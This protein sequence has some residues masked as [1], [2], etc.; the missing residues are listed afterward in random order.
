MREVTRGRSQGAS[1]AGSEDFLLPPFLICT[2]AQW[3]RLMELLGCRYDITEQRYVWPPERR[4]WEARF[5]LDSLCNTKGVSV[6]DRDKP[7]ASSYGSIF[8]SLFTCGSGGRQ[9]K[10]IISASLTKSENQPAKKTLHRHQKAKQEIEQ[11]ILRIFKE[12][13]PLL[14]DV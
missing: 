7:G 9:D 13:A 5:L 2:A 10:A 1:A 6:I 12:R 11:A 3:A 8:L 14:S 4:W